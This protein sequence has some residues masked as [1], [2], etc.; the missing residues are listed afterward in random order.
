MG[1]QDAEGG[2][3]VV[4]A[5]AKMDWCTGNMGMAGNSARSE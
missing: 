1:P 5:V 3:D 2:Y 4:E